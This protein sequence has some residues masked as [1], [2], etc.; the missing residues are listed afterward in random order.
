[1]PWYGI[2][3][4]GDG[5]PA[6]GQPGNAY[7]TRDTGHLWVYD[8]TRFVD[9]GP[10]VGPPGATPTFIA[11]NITPIGSGEAPRV[12]LVRLSN[13]SYRMDFS[14]PA[15]DSVSGGARP[16]FTY[17]QH[18]AALDWTFTHDLAFDPTDMK[19]TD[20]SAPD[21]DWSVPFDYDP[22]TK[23]YVL[24]FPIAVAGDVTVY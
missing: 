12:D 20:Y 7:I 17:V 4:V 18:T 10:I 8:G 3:G 5:L 19:I 6:T 14:L 21:A 24:H 1:M 16:S 23:T 9:S 2:G 22:A 13:T 15:G 11:G